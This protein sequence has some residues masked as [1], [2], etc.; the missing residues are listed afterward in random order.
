MT[1]KEWQRKHSKKFSSTL[2]GVYEAYDIEDCL[3]VREVYVKGKLVFRVAPIRPE[4]KIVLK[5]KRRAS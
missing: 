2:H 4:G 1:L 5:G 3:L